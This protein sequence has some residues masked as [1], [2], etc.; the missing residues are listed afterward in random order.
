[1]NT[2]TD[3]EEREHDRE[4]RDRPTHRG[5]TLDPRL[6]QMCGAEPSTGGMLSWYYRG[7]RYEELC[8]YC[9]EEVR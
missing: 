3:H 6:C 2:T 9:N 4:E 5:S 1:M 7:V 8:P